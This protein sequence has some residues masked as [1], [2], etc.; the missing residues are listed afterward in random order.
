M[1]VTAPA[2]RVVFATLGCKVAQYETE[3]LREAFLG[4][5][6][7]EVGEG[8]DIAVVNT[9]TVT[10]E[11]DRKCRQAIRRLHQK[12]PNARILAIGCYAQSH[13]E[14]VAELPGVTYV[15][16][17]A[18]K[19]RCVEVA[20]ASLGTPPTSPTLSVRPLDGEGY[21]TMA[22]SSAPRTRAYV[23]IADGC[24]CHCTYCAIPAARGPVRSRPREEILAEVERLIAGGTREVVLTGIETASYGRDLHDGYRLIDLLE[25]VDRLPIPRVRL[26]SL[27]PEVL[28]GDFITRLSR[29]SHLA[30]HLHLSVQ[31]GSSPV[32]A[33]MKRRYNAEQAMDAIL[34]LRAAIPEV[35]LTCDMIV[36]FPGE[37]K[38]DF[39]NTMKFSERAHFLSMHVFSYSARRGTPAATYPDK[40]GDAERAERSALLSALARRMNEETLSA[41]VFAGKPLSVLFETE[42]RGLAT[43]HTPSFLPVTV[44]ATGVAGEILTVYPTAVQNGQ[45]LATLTPPPEA[46]GKVTIGY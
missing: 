14:R 9:C 42:R 19:M 36:G 17:T 12:N 11:A 3:A 43:G 8:A 46:G 2:P 23:K 26:G 4:E 28:R 18:D 21:E 27:T 35:L 37:S 44:P 34:A 13:P 38:E 16:G 15:G 40:I 25:E 31:S 6:F 32:L 29:L 39:A 22:V 41:A 30:P 1:N 33:R 10:A 20:L 45:I 7:S 5:G 24:D